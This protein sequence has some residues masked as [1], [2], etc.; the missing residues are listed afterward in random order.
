MSAYEVTDV[1]LNRLDSNKYDVV[2]VNF[3]NPD[4][5]G[6]TGVLSAAIK[7][8]EAI[9]QCVGKVLDKVK[10]LGGA[11]IVTADHGNFERMWDTP[12]NQPHTAHTL[13]DVPLIVF[14][15]RYKNSKLR[16]GGRLAD[17]GPTLLEMMGLPKP[18]EMTGVS[19]LKP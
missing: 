7:A 18:E 1:V 19:L 4:M 8:A 15:E 13:F 12:K 11:A 3:A 5:V 16:E 9:D 17:I 2:V 10:S 6:H 14:D